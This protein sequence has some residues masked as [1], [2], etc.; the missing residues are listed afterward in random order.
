LHYI[1][2]IVNLGIKYQHQ[3]NGNIFMVSLMQ[4]ELMT[5]IRDDL[6]PTT[7]FLGEWCRN[8]V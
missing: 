6:L 3:A 2:S 1:K 4:I 5:K 7:I 8:L